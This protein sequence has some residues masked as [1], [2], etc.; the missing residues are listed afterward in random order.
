MKSKFNKSNLLFSIVF[1]LSLWELSSL[2]I[3]NNKLFPTLNYIAIKSLPSI[4]IFAGVPEPSHT[5]AFLVILT[6]LSKTIIRIIIGFSIGTFLGFTVGLLIHYFKS[7]RNANSIILLFFRS[8]PLFALIPLFL[9]WFGGNEAGIYIYIGFSV[10]I[11]IATNTYESV[12]NIP[13]NY[14]YLAHFSGASKFQ[15][16]KSVYLPAIFPEMRG[17]LRNVIGLLWAFSLGAEYLSGNSGIGYLVYQSYLY[18][19]MG[20]LIVFLI[21]YALC[22]LISFYLINFTLYLFHL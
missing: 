22:G 19:D 14:A 4:A 11:V 17:S 1:F 9:H 3:D 21:I 18:A 13:S 12:W 10:F 15:I 5:Q 6:H 7:T 2:I 8:V 20:K 16:L